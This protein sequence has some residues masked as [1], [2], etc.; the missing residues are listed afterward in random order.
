VKSLPI[1]NVLAR[2]YEVTQVGRTGVG[3]RDLILDYERFLTGAGCHEGE[4]RQ[5]AEQT[6]RDAE[7]RGLLTIESHKLD[8]GLLE[9]IRFRAANEPALFARIGELSPTERRRRLAQQFAEV[10]GEP[11]VPERWRASW[12][13]FC[14]SYQAAALTGSSMQPFERDDLAL[15]AELLSLLPRLLAW[16]SE[17]LIRFASCVLCG[18]SKRLEE[19]S[20]RLGQALAKA[21]RDEIRSLEDVNI[22]SNPRFALIHGPLRIKMEG[23]WLDLGLLQG[24]FRLSLED[25]AAAELI[26][27]TARRCITVENETSFYELAKLRSAELLV[28]TSFPGA[29]TLG[30]LKRLPTTLDFWHFG[31][32]DEPGFNILADLRTRSGRNFQ[33]LHMERGREP[34]EQE[35][36]GCP[37]RAHWPFY[38]GVDGGSGVT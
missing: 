19:L 9:R 2:R 34:F 25:I 8:P 28:Q 17:S 11:T 35:A 10:E 23:A 20:G 15:N 12:G 4:S 5:L 24:P 14:R 32:S 31:D 29:G 16:S 26:E 30:L 7:K 27:T 13:D 21:T 33:P 3:E 1:L 18:P 6:L 37:N 36:L 38:V 22:L